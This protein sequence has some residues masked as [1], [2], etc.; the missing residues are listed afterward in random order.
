MK[1]KIVRQFTVALT[2]AHRPWSGIVGVGRVAEDSEGVRSER[3]APPQLTR[4]YWE[5]CWLFHASGSWKDA[6]F[7]VDRITRFNDSLNK[8]D[9]SW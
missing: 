4:G 7:S 2:L 5:P 6:L 3:D 1:T 8:C 9:S